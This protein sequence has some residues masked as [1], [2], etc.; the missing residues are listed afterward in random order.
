MDFF[1]ELGTNRTLVEKLL[2]KIKGKR[3]Q[4][5]NTEI[6][7]KKPLNFRLLYCIFIKMYQGKQFYVGLN[8][9]KKK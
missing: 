2:I 4:A 5:K 1:K 7:L 3:L 8:L 6:T 9:E